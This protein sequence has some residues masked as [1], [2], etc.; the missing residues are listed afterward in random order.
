M[1]YKMF[2]RKSL[3][4]TNLLTLTASRPKKRRI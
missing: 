1:I 3:M 2:S 4:P